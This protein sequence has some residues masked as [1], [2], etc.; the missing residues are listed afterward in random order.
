M[1]YVQ[2]LAHTSFKNILLPFCATYYVD[3]HECHY[4]P[5]LTPENEAVCSTKKSATDAEI[6]INLLASYATSR[7]CTAG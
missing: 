6:W 5:Q 1:S 3:D 4:T 7:R 2:M